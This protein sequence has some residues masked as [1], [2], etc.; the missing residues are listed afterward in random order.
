MER[1]SEGCEKKLKIILEKRNKFNNVV[2]IYNPVLGTSSDDL[3]EFFGEY[4]KSGSDIEDFKYLH[5]QGYIV[6]NQFQE[7]PFK[8][9]KI[10]VLH[11]GLT[12]FE[13]INKTDNE[14]KYERKF[15]IKTMIISNSIAFIL[16]IFASILATVIINACR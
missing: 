14:K 1:L 4:W 13:K 15:T 12:Y 2:E 10:E 16:G 11:D 3:K 5:Q 8:I 6:Y 9:Y 7:N